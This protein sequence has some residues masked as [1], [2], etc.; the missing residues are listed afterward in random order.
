MNKRDFMKILASAGVAIPV[1]AVT[2]NQSAS[3]SV[4][5]TDPTERILKTGIIRAGYIVYAP[6]VIKDVATGKLSGFGY[7]FAQKLASNMGLKI[8]WVEEVF[9]GNAF[10]G[11]NTG[12]YDVV[13]ANL[14]PN[15][16]RARVGDFLDPLYYSGLCVYARPGD[17]RFDN[18]N[19][20]NDPAVKISTI[21]GEIAEM[22][23]AMRFPRAK[24]FSMPQSTEYSQ[25]LWNVVYGKADVAFADAGLSECIFD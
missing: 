21:D 23:A 5:D 6:F 20:I 13:I 9:F 15:A 7:D 22:V 25:L 1:A 12:R 8:E 18:L 19:A 4:V 14:W 16:T 17:H 11:L 2:A 24:L 3:S 10:E